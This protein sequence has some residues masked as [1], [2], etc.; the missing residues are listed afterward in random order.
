MSMVPARYCAKNSS[1]RRLNSSGVIP[2][3]GRG[4][5]N[6]PFIIRIDRNQCM[7]QIKKCQ[8]HRV[9][10][11]QALSIM[12]LIK[13]NGN[14]AARLQRITVHQVKKFHQAAE[15]AAEACQHEINH[16]ITQVPDRVMWALSR[17]HSTAL[18][19]TPVPVV[20]TRDPNPGGCEG[21]HVT[22]GQPEAGA[23][24]R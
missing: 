1:L 5:K 14:G 13:G 3:H 11:V 9:R 8:F 6:A 17:K 20:Q 21:R 19:I 15:V 22:S 24:R 18:S 16:F 12:V 4:G 10:P 23:L 2:A 7:V